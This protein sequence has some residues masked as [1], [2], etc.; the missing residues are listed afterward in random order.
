[1]IYSNNYQTE[2]RNLFTDPCLTDIST[3]LFHFL[4]TKDLLTC[5][6]VCKPS[7]KIIAQQDLLLKNE[8]KKTLNSINDPIAAFEVLLISDL[9]EA[10]NDFAKSQQAALSITTT[11]DQFQALLMLAIAQGKTDFFELKEAAK[12][13]A[14]EK[15]Q[16]DI[17]LN[18][19]KIEE[20]INE[21]TVSDEKLKFSNFFTIFNE[22]IKIDPQAAEKI[23]DFITDPLMKYLSYNMLLETDEGEACDCFE[24]T[25]K[26]TYYYN[27]SMYFHDSLDAFTEKNT[28]LTEQK[29]MLFSTEKALV[30]FIE[31]NNKAI[32]TYSRV[33]SLKTFFTDLQQIVKNNLSAAKKT[34]KLIKEPQLKCFFLIAI[35]TSEKSLKKTSDFF[36]KQIAKK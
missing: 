14:N 29:D 13:I 32:S 15:C 2:L 30:D 21:A 18:I 31:A 10:K 26:N 6:L 19:A 9:A 11:S 4:D 23:V 33:F 16:S 36:K 34:V 1:M 17:F 28:L 3:E 22:K 5:S 27:K 20:E 7:Q 24:E 8:L 35:L 12:S 25:E